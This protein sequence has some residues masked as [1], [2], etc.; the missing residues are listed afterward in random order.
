MN[1][2]VHFAVDIC[3]DLELENGNISYND[4]QVTAGYH[5]STMANFICNYGYSLS[6]PNTSTCQTS[7]NWTQLPTCNQSNEIVF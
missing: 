1:F 2:Y 7:E 3:R 4:S 6:G 5:L